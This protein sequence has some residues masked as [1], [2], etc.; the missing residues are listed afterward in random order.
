MMFR[1]NILTVLFTGAA[2]V[3]AVSGYSRKIA[4]VKAGY[5]IWWN[6][7][8]TSKTLDKGL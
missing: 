1:K 7:R 6:S 8:S 4:E 5:S 3:T 2:L